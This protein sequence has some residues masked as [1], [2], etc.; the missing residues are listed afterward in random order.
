MDE[1]KIELVIGVGD[2]EQA[3]GRKP[4]SGNEFEEFCYYCEK[5]LTNGHIDW[6]I[7]FSCAKDAM[8][9]SL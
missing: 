6:D 1:H 9:D 3:F 8:A 7:I 2:F 5:G 4:K